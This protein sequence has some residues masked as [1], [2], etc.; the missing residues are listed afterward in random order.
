MKESDAQTENN[1][2]KNCTPLSVWLIYA[3]TQGE[4]ETT[5]EAPQGLSSVKNLER[6]TYGVLDS[7]WEFM[8]IVRKCSDDRLRRSSGTSGLCN[9]LLRSEDNGCLWVDAE[10]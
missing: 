2:D 3:C 10:H 6:A 4:P 8:L 9:H 1:E 5:E 7:S